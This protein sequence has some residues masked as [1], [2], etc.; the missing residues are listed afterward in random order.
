MFNIAKKEWGLPIPANPVAAM[1]FKAGDD[2]RERRVSEKEWSSLLHAVDAARN[3]HIKPLMLLAIE[4][5]MRR[6]EMLKILPKHVNL[7]K[8]EVYVPP[9]KNNKARTI[10]LTQ[11]AFGLLEKRLSKLVRTGG[12]FRPRQRRLSVRGGECGDVQA[13]KTKTSGSMTF[14]TRPSADFSRWICQC[15]RWPAKAGTR[16]PECYFGMAMRCERRS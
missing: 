9:G 11:A 6:S 3:P 13:L 5:G 1:G 10:V 4:T 14:D 7:E 12:C 16:T 8:Y 2:Q 15:L